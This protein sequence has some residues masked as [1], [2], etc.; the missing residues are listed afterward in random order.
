MQ[1]DAAS[2]LAEALDEACRSAPDRVALVHGG[3][4]TTFAELRAAAAALAGEYRARGIAPGERVVCSVSNRPEH[5]VALVGAWWAGVVHVCADYRSTVREL[6]HVVGLAEA[7][8]LVYEAPDGAAAP[9]ALRPGLEV[10]TVGEGIPPAGAEPVER[11]TPSPDEPAIVFVTSGTTG[12]PKATIGYH[13]NLAARWQR[14]WRWLGF[15]PDDVHLAQMPLS[16]GFGLLTAVSA[17]LANGS[18]VL[19]DRFSPARALDAIE[20]ERVTVLGGAPA[21]YR[22]L[23]HQQAEAPRDVTSLR[24]GIGTAAAFSPELVAKIRDVLGLRLAIMYGSSEGIGVATTDQEDIA[25]GAVGRLSPGAATIV[26]PDRTPLP[27]GE[28]GEIAFSR[29]VFPV[30]YWGRDGRPLGEWYYSG[31]LGRLDEE[32]RLYVY[33]RLKHQIDRGGL[34]IDPVEVEGA[35][36]RSPGVADAAVL[37]VPDPVVGERVCACV[38]A[39]AGEAPTLEGIRTALAA[40]LAPYKLPEDLCVL[41]EIPRTAIGKTD[42]RALRARIEEARRESVRV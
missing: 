11:A 32:G 29:A 2:S 9:E 42:V 33:G 20:S 1:A 17:L 40:E 13:G 7:R 25:L 4:R 15:R 3:R 5:V 8:A 19:L 27:V 21:H 41:D 39:D 16:H 18:V 36:A 34:K 28:L 26:A 6:A 14:L 22:M 10:F 35:L 24:F 37:G 38:V 23:L 31:D 30:R 12:A